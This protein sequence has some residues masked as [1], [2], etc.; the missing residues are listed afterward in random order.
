MRM[1]CEET[2]VNRAARAEMRGWLLL[3]LGALAV[4]G[5]LA[6]LLAA[7]RTPGAQ[8]WLPWGTDFFH[9]GLVTHVVFSFQIWLLA[10]LGALTV[11]AA[12]AGRSLGFAALVLAVAGSVMLLVPTLAGAGEASLN[13]YVPVLVHPLY[14]LGL[15][16]LAGG[17][18]LAAARTLAA[19]AAGVFA[20]GMRAASACLLVALLCFGLATALIPA[21]TPIE[22]LNER[23]FW[24]GGHVLQFVNT[25]L[26]L[27]GWQVLC[28][29]AFGR[30][31]L[32]P[33]TARTA[34]AALVVVALAAPFAYRLDVLG[35]PH[36]QAFTA[37]LWVGLPLPPLVM[38][39]GVAWR[40]WAYWRARDGFSL[41][42][43]SQGDSTCKLN[44]S[45]INKLE[46][47]S[48]NRSARCRADLLSSRSRGPRDPA[49]PAVLA[50][51]LS[52]AVFGL[53]GFAGFALGVADT[54]T[55]SHYHAVIGG[56]NL[57]LMGLIHTELLPALRR[58]AGG[59]RWV[60]AQFHLY[61]WGQ[62]L[63][64]LGFY[65][66]GVAGVARKTA[67]AEQGLDSAVKLAAMGVVGLGGAIAVLGG[68]IFVVQVLGCLLR[69]EGGH[70]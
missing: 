18:G 60:R 7:S 45:L 64:A 33:L 27:V 69:R 65:M 36:R 37:L 12:P 23:L 53:G 26:L 24:G 40:L 20:A 13:N 11:P 1:A 41:Q 14:Y 29:R 67:G 5:A 56:V 50:L 46:G 44:P 48:D 38:G 54:R 63:H 4:A 47:D 19:H 10:M 42:V 66:A 31:A 30:G 16:L 34:Y 52:L 51:A 21:G 61:G 3:A 59:G 9:K 39:A 6:L 22:H 35:L 62:L 58:S 15:A 70:G 49:S 55:P 57:A 28:Q 17:I 8:E 25:A 2:G 68:V 32:P 43:G